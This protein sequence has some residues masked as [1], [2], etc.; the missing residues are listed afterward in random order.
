MEKRLKLVPD[1]NIAEGR[2]YQSSDTTDIRERFRSVDP[3]WNKRPAK[4]EPRAKLRNKL[5]GWD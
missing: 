4:L 3:L 1:V 5:N 2:K